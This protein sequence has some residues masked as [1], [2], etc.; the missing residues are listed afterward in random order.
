MNQAHCWT[1][2]RHFAVGAVLVG[3]AAGGAGAQ[4]ASQVTVA[5]RGGVESFD[6]AAS[7]DKA[8]IIGLDAMYG[9]NDWLSIGPTLSLGRA[10]TTGSHFVSVLTY[11][12]FNL[13][14]TTTF[15]YAAQ[16]ISVFDGAMNVRV[17][18]PGRKLSPYATAG[19][20]GYSMF[21]DVQSNRGERHHVGV[22]FNVGAGA[23]YAL[24]ERAG[25]TF[26]VRSSSFT[27]YDRTVLDPRMAC[28]PT[29]PT[30]TQCPRVEY[31]LYAQDFKAP[32]KSKKTVTNL[33]FSVGFSY[34][35]SFFGG[36]AGGGQ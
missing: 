27:D 8:A 4:T 12:V 3:L 25:I 19:V 11:G 1:S 10:N 21:L 22:S 23:L 31:S 15:H 34:V 9:I 16:P 30:T 26:D 6:K 20:G 29:V 36:G 35:P 2:I 17:Q 24:S 5:V 28:E 14:D 13:G 32:P 7:I 33:L 18:L